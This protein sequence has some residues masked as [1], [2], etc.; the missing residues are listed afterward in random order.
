[1]SEMILKGHKTELN[2]IVYSFVLHIKTFI[3]LA[4]LRFLN[5]QILHLIIICKNACFPQEWKSKA[6]VK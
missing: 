5:I 2:K 3:D 6:A 1:M 4:F